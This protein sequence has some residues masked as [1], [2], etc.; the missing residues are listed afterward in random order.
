MRFFSKLLGNRPMKFVCF[1]FTDIVSG[2]AVNIYRDDSEKFWMA[3]NKWGWFR[4]E[5]TPKSVH[6]NKLFAEG[7]VP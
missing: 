7:L 3:N 4:V 5:I 6:Y 1:M 2:Q